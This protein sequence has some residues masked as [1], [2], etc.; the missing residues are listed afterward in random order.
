MGHVESLLKEVK[1]GKIRCNLNITSN[2]AL[3]QLQY[4]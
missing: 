2:W 1:K 3:H 4:S